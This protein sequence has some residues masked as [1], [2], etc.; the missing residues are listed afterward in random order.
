MK[1][2]LLLG[3]TGSI[4]SNVLD[5]VRAHPGDFRIAGMAARRPTDRFAALA[6]EFPDA[7]L[8]ATHEIESDAFAAARAGRS[9]KFFPG[10]D[11]AEDM[12]RSVDADVCVAAVS[13]T[14]GLPMAFAAVERGMDIMLA[15]KEVLVSAGRLFVDAVEANGVKL[16][17]LDSEHVALWQCLEGRGRDRVERV[18]ITASGGPFREWSAEQM[19]A[20]TPAQALRH[21]VWNMGPKISIDSA[22]LA[23]K[24][25]ELIEA[26]F[27]FG[28]G[29]DQMTALL[30][31]QSAIHGLVE[32]DDGSIMA[33]LGA[34]DMRQPISHMMFYP[35]GR[36]NSLRRLDLAA[37]AR[38]DFALPDAARFPMLAL[39][40]EAGRKGGG[41]PALYNAANEA[42]V[43]EFLAG[44]LSFT[45]I[46]EAVRHAMSGGAPEGMVG[47]AEVMEIHRTARE[48]VRGFV[49]AQV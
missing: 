30:H 14:G 16:L 43:G 8:A 6:R 18:Y 20:A 24:A 26:H 23:N 12:I 41:H 22:T 39:G 48:L 19:A 17:P 5:V 37:L 11:G 9:G 27:L 7:A 44:R 10:P 49:E 45:G 15:N 4:G 35:E 32:F 28:F 25:L 40:L 42:A 3:A 47:I 31:P 38:L 29:F 34:N 13:G 33:H 2:I 46:A 21:P 1:R 36:K